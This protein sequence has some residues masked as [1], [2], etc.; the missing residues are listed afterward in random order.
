MK[1]EIDE[2]KNIINN[3]LICGNEKAFDGMAKKYIKFNF[4]NNLFIYT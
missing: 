2:E 3:I 4:M 1:E